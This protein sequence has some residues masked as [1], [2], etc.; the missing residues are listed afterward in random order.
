MI[1]RHI[2]IHGSIFAVIVNSYIFLVMITISPRVW[3]YTD[4]PQVI[5]DKVPPQ[6]KKEKLT[7]AIIG[8]PWITFVLGYPIYSTYLLKVK[9]GGNISILI[10]FCNLFILFLMANVGDLV[11]LDWLIISKITPKFVIIPG[12]KIEDYK[13]FS[14]HYKGHAWSIVLLIL[15]SLVIAYFVGY[16]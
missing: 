6:T 11:I 12:T 3:G 7:A 4:Y 15:L 10:A 1:I 5:K 14:H 9:L 13:D 16:F 8:L 2:I